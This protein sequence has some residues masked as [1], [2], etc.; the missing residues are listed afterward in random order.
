MNEEFEEVKEH[1]VLHV[2][3]K[4][5]KIYNVSRKYFK[6]RISWCE[7]EEG[8]MSCKLRI[9]TAWMNYIS[10]LPNGISNTNFITDKAVSVEIIN[11]AIIWWI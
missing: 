5:L 1:S 4:F 9:L 7:V 2:T 6:P 10:N 3:G 11:G 8:V